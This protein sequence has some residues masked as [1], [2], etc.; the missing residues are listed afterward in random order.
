VVDNLGLVIG[1][2][3][4]V[5]VL[6]VV[7]GAL[8]L[9][10]SSRAKFM[11]IDCIVKDV[12]AVEEPWRRFRERGKDLFWIRFW[13]SLV[14]LAVA[15]VGLGLGGALAWPDIVRGEL[16]HSAILGLVV[17]LGV[18]VL[19]SIPLGIA[20]A[21]IEDFVVPAMYA[22]DESVRPAWERVKS[23]VIRG[24]VVT[25]FLYYVVKFVIGLVAG[26]IAVAAMCLTCCLAAL[27]YL[28]SV[29]LL[30]VFVF[31]RGY[32]LCFLEQFG[33]DWRFFPAGDPE[34]SARP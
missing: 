1:V 10:V 8:L 21:L 22:R 23:E 24:N 17:G 26:V 7:I 15:L 12:A 20:G 32:S 29:V 28:S 2:G 5:L 3:V 13:L 6:G 31:T 33:P 27:P 9:W 19:G 18:I 4:A 30:P 16:E 34:L 11:F 14:E 25:I